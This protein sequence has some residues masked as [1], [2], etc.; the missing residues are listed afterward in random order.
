M[1]R[2]LKYSIQNLFE[3]SV[4]KQKIQD[5]GQLGP[6]FYEAFKFKVHTIYLEI[7]F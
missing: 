5:E 6:K 7:Y 1:K 4:K 3:H 2:E